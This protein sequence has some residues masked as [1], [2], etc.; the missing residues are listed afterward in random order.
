MPALSTLGLFALAALALIVI[1]GPAVLYIVAGSI[2]HGRSAGLACVAGV[3]TGGL[4][5]VAAA[6]VGVSAVLASSATAF[7]AVR[8][9]GA[10]YLVVM[11]MRTLL[12]RSADEPG[13]VPA[14]SLRRAWLQGAVVN[15]LNP[16]TALFFLAFLPQFVDPARGNAGLQALVLGA[17]FVVLAMVSD[18][19]YALMA[20]GAA[21][22]LRG[23]G[24]MR[25]GRRLAGGVYIA[26][27][28]TAA[29][30]GSRSTSTH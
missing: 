12:S 30:T 5:H 7:S 10:A 25:R 17:V 11:G 15:I 20:S 9:L 19:T 8:Y 23:R 28:A 13:E 29:L 3:G 18:S 21:D 16:K 14:R 1:P 4:V 22:W 24:V 27:G 26:L 2:D 6:A